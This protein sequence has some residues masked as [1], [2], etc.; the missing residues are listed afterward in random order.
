[1]KKYKFLSIF[2]LLMLAIFTQ[3]NAAESPT[4]VIKNGNKKIAEAVSS[5]KNPA[6]LTEKI[7][8]ILADITNFNTLSN[9]VTAGF[10]KNLTADQCKLFNSSF[11]DLIKTS[12]ASKLSKYKSEKI[13]YDKE[14]IKGNKAT[15]KT[16]LVSKD[17]QVRIDYQ[18]EKVGNKWQIVNYIVEDIDTVDNYKKQFTRMF[19]KDT[20]EKIIN[21]LKQKTT[22]YKAGK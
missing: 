15:V 11:I 5:T 14:E 12:T 22:T 6:Q 9:N 17:K 16:T 10:C 21:N 3:S 13:N 19:K 4:D 1:M 20:F 18:L 7:S 8:A 2:A